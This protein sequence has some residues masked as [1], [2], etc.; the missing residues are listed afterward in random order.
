MDDY[1]PLVI[2][3]TAERWNRCVK[4]VDWFIHNYPNIMDEC[5]IELGLKPL[6]LE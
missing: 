1:K 4:I 5:L 6:H 2:G 3:Y